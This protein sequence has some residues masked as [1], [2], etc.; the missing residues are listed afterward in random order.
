MIVESKYNVFVVSGKKRQYNFFYFCR[1]IKHEKAI[2]KISQNFNIIFDVL[3]AKN[4]G[5]VIAL[6]NIKLTSCFPERD[7]ANFCTPYQFRCS[8]TNLCINN[9]RVCD[10]TQDCQFGD[11]ETQN[12]G[13]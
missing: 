11:D 3:P 1:W 7:N 9:T 13:K 4:K 8:V 12:C 6:D 10:I 2:G 5:A